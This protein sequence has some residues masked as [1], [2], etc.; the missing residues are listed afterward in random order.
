MPRLGE[1]G[2]DKPRQHIDRAAGGERHDNADGLRGEGL[3]LGGGDG[4][5]ESDRAH[6]DR[7]G[8]PEP[9]HGF[10]LSPASHGT[11]IQRGS[12][13][14]LRP[15]RTVATV[16]LMASAAKNGQGALACTTGHPC[17]AISPTPATSRSSRITLRKAASSSLP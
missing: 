14:P 12:Q 13:R 1:L 9:P 4:G 3:G 8:N 16:A 10:L 6:H 7:K 15:D 5:G 11:I 17:A 2:A